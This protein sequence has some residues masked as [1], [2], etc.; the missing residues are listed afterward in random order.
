MNNE[1]TTSRCNES[2]R[3]RAT[4]EEVGGSRRV[5]DASPLYRRR[6]DGQ[7]GH[8]RGARKPSGVPRSGALRP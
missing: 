2:A 7:E 8:G 4:A 5:A 6:R 1:R 3:N